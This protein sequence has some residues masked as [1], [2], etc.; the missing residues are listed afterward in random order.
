MVRCLRVSPGFRFEECDIDQKKVGDVLG[1]PIT[2]VGVIPEIDA[3]I[4]GLEEGTGEEWQSSLLFS[5]EVRGD[6]M[7]VATN[8]EGD[9]IDLDVERAR[10]LLT[11]ET[12]ASA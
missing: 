10:I 8:S 4:C 12:S 5:G 9:E 3:V 2:F 1:G 11:T 6:V 7:L